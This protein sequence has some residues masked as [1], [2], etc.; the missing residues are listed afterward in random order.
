MVE[1][2]TLIVTRKCPLCGRL[3]VGRVTQQNG[4]PHGPQRCVGWSLALCPLR[5]VIGEDRSRFAAAW[6]RRVDVG[7]NLVKSPPKLSQ[8][9][10]GPSTSRFFGAH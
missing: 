1:D 5:P 9:L 2:G 7:T 10:I 8:L 6:S 3:N 4:Q